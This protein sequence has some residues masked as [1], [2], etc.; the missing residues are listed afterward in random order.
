MAE[1]QR[2]GCHMNLKTADISIISESPLFMGMS[3]TEIRERLYLLK[4][5]R[6][7]YAKEAVIYHS[8]DRIG[9]FG[10]VL[11]GCVQII[12]ADFWGNQHILARIEAGQVFAE[13]YACVGE[14]LMVD[15]TAAEP[16]EILFLNASVLFAADGATVSGRNI[17]A[18]NLLRISMRKNLMLSR[19]ICHTTPKTIRERLLS[20][21]SYCVVQAGKS[22][23]D[24]PYDR[25]G[26]AD[27]LSVER[28]ALSKELGKMRR[29]GIIDFQKNHFILKREQ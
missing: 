23:F 19:R 26:L 16:S 18:D 24:I 20:Y 12:Q 17:M 14:P 3:E 13:T 21:L 28:S 6:K 1:S 4:A 25:Q 2:K 22:A 15:V 27:Y 11:Q 7:S 10:L 5:E 8:G 9:T 29:E